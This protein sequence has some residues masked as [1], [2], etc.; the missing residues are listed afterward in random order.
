[1][2][3]AIKLTALMMIV[4]NLVIAEANYDVKSAKIEFDI[5]STQTV[6]SISTK[7]IGKKR[8]IINN[9]GEQELAELSSIS[10]TIANGKVSVDKNHHMSYL[11]GP[12][13]YAID[14]NRKTIDRS[15]GFMG[16]L[17]GTKKYKGS[18]DN[19]L[20]LQKMKKVGTD[21]VAGHTCDVWQLGEMSKTCF[22]KG[23]PLREESTLMGMKRVVVAT[24]A[25]F[26]IELSK[27]DFKLPNF[28]INGKIYTKIQ[29]EEMD[30]KDKHIAGE[31]QKEQK[32][33]IAIMQEAFKKAGVKNGKP[34]KE[35]MKKV[36]QYMEP[37]ILGKQK[38]KILEDGK[39]LD[40]AKIC[41]Q[42]ANSVKEAN[43]CE[44][45]GD[46][47]EP[48]VHHTWSDA[49]KTKILKQI[50]KYESL[51]PCVEKAQSMK[52]LQVCFPQE[53]D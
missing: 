39:N 44:L 30:N 32:E 52:A 11:N 23:F 26:D 36:R 6:G 27:E 18:V 24:K 25:E 20:K 14:F 47:S 33:A 37:S 9:Y 13:R 2:K 22:Y 48:R 34:T 17:F 49:D 19:M 42:N 28:P 5:Q 31:E 43:I 16:M 21:T 8:I 29:L 46:R 12:I 41:F 40:Q 4:S 10:K 51:I 38:R 15:K 1:M 35:Q 53:D 3:K 45:I 50:S 7:M